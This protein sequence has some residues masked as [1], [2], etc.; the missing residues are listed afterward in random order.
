MLI[1]GSSKYQINQRMTNYYL[2][3]PLFKAV[4][5]CCIYYILLTIIQTITI[6]V[7]GLN[8]NQVK[9]GKIQL[10]VHLLTSLISCIGTYMYF[11]YFNKKY[12]CG[13]F[14]L[15]FYLKD[16]TLFIY[17]SALGL[18]AITVIFFFV[19]ILGH[20]RVSFNNG[21]SLIA[22]IEASALFLLVAITEEIFN[23]AI[24]LNYLLRSNYGRNYAI[25]ISSL[26]FTIFHSMNPNLGL[27]GSITIFLSGI[28]LATLFIHCNY[29]IWMSI[30][31]HWTWNFFQ[32]IYGFAVSGLSVPS[33][34]KQDF[35]KDDLI[36]GGSFGLEGSVITVIILLISIKV[37]YIF[38]NR[39]SAKST[40][41]TLGI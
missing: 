41:N 3:K 12:N 28:I 36:N 9:A 35:L 16:F 18:I 22:G 33:V 20:T 21:Y 5:W 39:Y 17:G 19:Y 26:I 8:I 23:R 14:K 15:T 10:S 37:L 7:F 40:Q 2:T 34:L 24:I 29:N 11:L 38:Y 25:I 1:S 27:V 4:L 30:G 13:N 32:S 31:L 6:I